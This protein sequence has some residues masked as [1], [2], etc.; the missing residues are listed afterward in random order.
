MA[1]KIKISGTTSNTFSVGANGTGNI[2]AGN[3]LYSNGQSIS[4]GSNNGTITIVTKSSNTV[5]STSDVGKMII[6]V[7]AN[8]Y[9]NYDIPNVATAGFSVGSRIEVF[10]DSMAGFIIGPASNSGVTV[11]ASKTLNSSSTIANVQSA[12]LTMLSTDKWYVGP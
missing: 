9:I 8:S 2:T 12:T 7:T 11:L 1:N 10:A 3:Y 6:N 4:N 5:A